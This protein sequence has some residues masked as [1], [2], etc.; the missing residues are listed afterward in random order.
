[1]ER[2]TYGVWQ[3][4][5][6]CRTFTTLREAKRYAEQV[7]ATEICLMRGMN[8]QLLCQYHPMS[9]RLERLQT[10]AQAKAKMTK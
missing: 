7:E 9:E 2:I 10:I 3:F 1:M 8:E 6:N 4:V 5:V